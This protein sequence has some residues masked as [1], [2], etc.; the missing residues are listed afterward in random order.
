MKLSNGKASI[1]QAAGTRLVRNS[2]L[3]VA[4]LGLLLG[5]W[6]LVGQQSRFKVVSYGPG[7]TRASAR[8]SFG[9]NHVFFVGTLW[10]KLVGPLEAT[11]NPRA[12]RALEFGTE[13]PATMLWISYVHPENGYPVGFAK[14][15]VTA[16]APLPAVFRPPTLR[17]Q[18]VTAAGDTND[19]V[20]RTCGRHYPQNLCYSAWIIPGRIE[21]QSGGR[22]RLEFT[23]GVEVAVFRLR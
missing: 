8:C 3:A 22:I 23:N 9:T 1:Q 20:Q 4:A 2:L 14:G 6:L 15:R 18:W 7:V 16:G 5:I 12:K 11:L 13:A 19:L 17:A 21:D 10:D